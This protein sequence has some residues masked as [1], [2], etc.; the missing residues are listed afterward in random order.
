MAL[1]APQP[2][3][4]GALDSS[5]EYE[6]GQARVLRSWALMESDLR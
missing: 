6:S 1:A 2:V 5:D 3:V 4:R